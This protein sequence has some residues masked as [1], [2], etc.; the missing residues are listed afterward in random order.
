MLI[1]SHYC[2]SSPSNCKDDS[3]VNANSWY[4]LGKGNL[5]IALTSDH[6][7]FMGQMNVDGQTNCI[8]LKDT[9]YFD[10]GCTGLKQS[11]CEV[12]GMFYKKLAIHFHEYCLCNY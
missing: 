6:L 5:K 11:V 3:C 2:S 9:N 12:E 8:R 4:W 10:I 7:G 1:L